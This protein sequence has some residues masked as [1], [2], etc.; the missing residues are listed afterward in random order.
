MQ[1]PLNVSPVSASFIGLERLGILLVLSV[2]CTLLLPFFFFLIPL[3][4]SSSTSASWC[5]QTRQSWLLAMRA[6]LW[7]VLVCVCLLAVSHPGTRSCASLNGPPRALLC[8][9]LA[10]GKIEVILFSCS[11]AVW[12]QVCSSTTE[13]W[14]PV[15]T[16]SRPFTHAH[17]RHA[18]HPPSRLAV[19]FD[20]G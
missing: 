15:L 5:P 1:L 13:E 18:T 17:A 2:A 14:K 9:S 19:P 10:L 20:L 6:C 3:H 11:S 8:F 7:L 4:A 16:A 12:L